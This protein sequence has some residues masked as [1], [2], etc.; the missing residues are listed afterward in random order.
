MTNNTA[1]YKAMI[2]KLKL[3]KELGARKVHL[4]SDSELA[5]KQINVECRVIDDKLRRYREQFQFLK[6]QFES[7]E[8]I[9]MEQFESVRI[10]GIA[11]RH[12]YLGITTF[13]CGIKAC[14]VWL[15]S[16]HA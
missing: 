11:H 15:L 5:V 2:V 12:D 8:L 4:H 7:V 1:E 13:W 14:F 10:S 6:E 9:Y 16:K 3:A